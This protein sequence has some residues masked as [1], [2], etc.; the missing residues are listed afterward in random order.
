MDTSNINGVEDFYKKE[1]LLYRSATRQARN[2][3]RE[4]VARTIVF[5]HSEDLTA[6]KKQEIYAQNDSSGD[7]TSGDHIAHR[8]TLME[9]VYNLG[10]YENILEKIKRLK[11]GDKNVAEM[12]RVVYKKGPNEGFSSKIKW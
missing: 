6:Q 3:I 5:D 9:Q 4:E 8:G 7:H 2:R 11:Y 1:H 12:L 10:N